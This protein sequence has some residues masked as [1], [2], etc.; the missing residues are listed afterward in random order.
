[1]TNPAY[2][3]EEVKRL[4]GV[5][6]S[7]T[8]K[9]Y[10][11]LTQRHTV[12]VHWRNHMWRWW[13][14]SFD[15]HTSVVLFSFFFFLSHHISPLWWLDITLP[16]HQISQSHSEDMQLTFWLF[17]FWTGGNF[18]SCRAETASCHSHLP[19]I[20][21]WNHVREKVCSLVKVKR[22][23]QRKTDKHR[24]GLVEQLI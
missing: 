24:A 7:I 13:H 17:T 14:N 21:D 4:L 5:C 10:L 8:E 3:W 16:G 11:S 6:V 12:S 15:P 22:Q 23:P 9:L 1:M 18:P 20:R 19:L 2:I